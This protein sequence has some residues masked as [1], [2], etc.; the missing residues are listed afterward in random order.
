MKKFITVL[1]AIALLASLVTACDTTPTTT[2]SKQESK[3]ES[4]PA[5]SEPAAE[6]LSIAYIINMPNDWNQAYLAAGKAKCDEL[7]IEYIEMNPDLDVQKQVDQVQSCISQGVTGICIQQLDNAALAPIMK[8]AAE[9]GITI[10]THFEFDPALN[11][12]ELLYFA[13][14]G[15]KESG[16]LSGTALV[17]ALGGKG[18][19]GVIAS[20]AGTDNT[21]RR[22]AGFD[23]AIAGT[24]IEV[25]GETAC[26]EDVQKA[27]TAT[28]DMLTAHPD[29][30][31]IFSMSDGMSQGII[32]AV[33]AAGKMD[34]I[35]ISSISANEFGMQ[36][37]R[38]G[39]LVC[40]VD[41]PTAWFSEKGAEIIAAVAAGE[42]V[43][44]VQAYQP[45]LITKENVDTIV[46]K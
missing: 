35:K 18:K 39:E 8:K 34:Q 15:Q 33:K 12:D 24:E 17:E 6:K 42:T 2:P 25:I 5:S 13:V 21:I 44:R 41:V 31:G 46:I 30:A 36:A 23:E 9:A 29:L 20:T 40:T 28:E 16:F 26:G 22:R 38:D 19:V 14:Y 11:M 4:K 27:M 10:V 32:Q 37:V 45:I 1:L 7:G 3:E 43:E